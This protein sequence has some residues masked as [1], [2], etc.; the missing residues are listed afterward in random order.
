MKSV[1]QDLD[2]SG[3]AIREVYVLGV[4]L[5]PFGRFADKDVIEIGREA[6]L[7][8]IDDAGLPWQKVGAAYCGTVFAGPMAGNRVLA[9]V[10]LTGLPIVNVENAC[11]SGGSALRE[12]YQSVAGGFSDVALAFG[13]EKMP[14][15]FIAGNP[16]DWFAV[17]GLAVNPQYFALKA[18]WHMASFGTTEEQ[19]VQV[20]VKNHR[21]GVL[22]PFAMYRKAMSFDEIAQSQ[23]VNDPLRLLMLCAPNEGA[24]AVVLCSK[25]IAKEYTTKLIKLAAIVL[26]SPVYGTAEVPHISVSARVEAPTVTMTAA[27]EAYETAGIGPTDLDLVELQDTDSASEIIYT[28][29][30]GLCQRG[31]GG[32]L[33]DDGATEINGRIPVNVSGGLLSKGEPLG[34]SALAQVVE[35]VWQ[36]R[37]EAGPR[38]VNNPRTGLTHVYGAL[39]NCAVSVLQG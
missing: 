5:H 29:E 19:L 35:V 9:R 21:N 2:D 25:D 36:L 30:L 28:E 18:R 13:M 38:Q 11:A 23:M 32:K 20:S 17:M 27:Q 3:G 37:G 26:D 14:K 4:G 1:T 22:N 7:R 16:N 12:A 34:A 10:G 33:V 8:A 15:G 39:G 31:E 6:V 24:A